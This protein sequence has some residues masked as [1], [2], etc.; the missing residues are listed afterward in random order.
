MSLYIFD[1]RRIGFSTT[2]CLNFQVF[3]PDPDEKLIGMESA[4]R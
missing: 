4:D 1:S 2:K 3:P